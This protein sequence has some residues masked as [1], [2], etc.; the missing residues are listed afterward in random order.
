VGSE[1]EEKNTEEK[2]TDEEKSD[3]SLKSPFGFKAISFLLTYFAAE[4][5]PF[6]DIANDPPPKPTPSANMS[7]DFLKSKAATEI[8]N[9]TPVTV[10]ASTID[11][12]TQAMQLAADNSKVTAAATQELARAATFRLRQDSAEALVK[13]LGEDIKEAKAELAELDD[14]DEKIAKRKEIEDWKKERTDAIKRQK[15]IIQEGMQPTQS[16]PFPSSSATTTPPPS[17]LS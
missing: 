15:A 13:R 1:D 11:H 9:K 14:E 5:L 8:S 6:Y 3:S 16:I 4:R 7:P 12:K 10:K 17:P 2:N